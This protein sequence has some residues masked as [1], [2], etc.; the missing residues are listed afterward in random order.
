MATIAPL[1]VNTSRVTKIT[2][3]DDPLIEPLGEFVALGHLDNVALVDT[4]GEMKDCE[5]FLAGRELMR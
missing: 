4:N 5:M 3:A 1:P 2:A